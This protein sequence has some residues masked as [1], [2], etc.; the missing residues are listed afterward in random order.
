MTFIWSPV[1]T[2][3]WTLN[4]TLRAVSRATTGTLTE[5]ERLLAC[6]FR[7]SSS[8]TPRPWCV[9]RK[10]NLAEHIVSTSTSSLTSEQVWGNVHRQQ[11]VRV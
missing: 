3:G 5:P 2:S 11:T 10:F 8:F 7:L 4:W 1:F 6:W 9:L